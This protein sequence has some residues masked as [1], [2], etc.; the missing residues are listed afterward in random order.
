MLIDI[1][2]LKIGRPRLIGHKIVLKRSES[3]YL[4]DGVTY[5]ID[6][7]L[8]LFGIERPVLESKKEETEVQLVS[9]E[10]SNLTGLEFAVAIIEPPARL[11]QYGYI[12]DKKSY[13]DYLI[14]AKA[15]NLLL[16][17]SGLKENNGKFI[18]TQPWQ[19]DYSSQDK[20]CKD[21]DSDEYSC[22]YCKKKY[23]N[24]AQLFNHIAQNH[25]FVKSQ[26]SQLRHQKAKEERAEPHTA[27]S[28]DVE[29]TIEE[30]NSKNL[31]CPHC[32]KACKSA[33]GLT[34]H[35]NSR[36]KEHAK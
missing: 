6:G 17:Y 27:K 24:S 35:I 13:N 7:V 30:D 20:D 26:Q 9:I 36:H 31:K 8:R 2:N 32:G 5:D 12:K 4:I 19:L 23:V 10:K 28:I 21:L 25:S 33:F 3:S 34:N 18:A 14:A 22:I 11:I 29:S 15:R 16:Y 1:D